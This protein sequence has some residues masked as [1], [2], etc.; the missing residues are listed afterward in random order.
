[1]ARPLPG[2][3]R[4]GLVRRREWSRR[5]PEGAAAAARPETGPAA[6]RRRPRP[7]V[8]GRLLRHRAVLERHRRARPRARRRHRPGL[9]RAGRRRA[10]HR[11]VHA[12]AAGARQ[13]R[14]RPPGAPRLRRGVGGAG[15]DARRA[16]L[17]GHRQHRRPRRDRA[18][19]R[20]RDGRRRP[21]G[22]RRRRLGPDAV[23]RRVHL[24]AGQR[25]P[26]AR[27]GGPLPPPG[28]GH[29]RRRLPRRPRHQGGRHR[30]PPGAGAHGRHGAPV[31]GRPLPL[32]PHAARRQEPLRLHQRARHLRDDRVGPQ[33]GARPLR[34]L[35]QRRGAGRRLRRARRRRGHALLPRRGP[36]ARQP[37]RIGH[38]ASRRRRL[39]PQPPGH[40]RRGPREAC[41]A[42]VV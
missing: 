4:L 42:E 31:R 28:Q 5:R 27:G 19:P 40:A 17:Q 38:A 32:L 14:R 30:R 21:P 20:P 29:R 7:S 26:G 24:G 23:Q 41:R 3:R 1:M 6:Q 33:D 37:N 25:E 22:V 34:P 16:H 11:Q 10:R 8:R 35:P 36:G 13:R 2:L 18:R 39:R 12:P 9:A 15:Q